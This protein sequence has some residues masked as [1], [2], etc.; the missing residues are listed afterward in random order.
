MEPKTTLLPGGWEEEGE[1]AKSVGCLRVPALV[2][3]SGYAWALLAL[4][5][6]AAGGG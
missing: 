1:W 2:C 5:W 3:F 4:V 6:A